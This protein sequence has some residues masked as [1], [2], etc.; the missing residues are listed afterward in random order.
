[1]EVY[2]LGFWLCLII[3]CR[4][5]LPVEDTTSLNDSS[6]EPVDFYV[7]EKKYTCH[8]SVLLQIYIAIMLLKNDWVC[9]L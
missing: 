7:E 9:P 4:K 3:C 8:A 5:L 2:K 6:H 1:M